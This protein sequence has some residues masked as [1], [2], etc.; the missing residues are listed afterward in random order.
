MSEQEQPD[1]LQQQQQ[2]VDRKGK[3]RAIIH[4]PS[5]RTPLLGGTSQI[6]W[7]V[8]NDVEDSSRA[9]RTL[10]SRLATVFLASLSICTVVF[11]AIA[12]LAWSYAAKAADLTPEDLIN[13]DLVFDGPQKVDLHNVTKDGGIWVTV[14]GRMGV[15]VGDAMGINSDPDDGLLQR[16][17]KKIGRQG[18]RTLHTVSVNLS[19]VTV[20][21]EF[22]PFTTLATLDILPLDLPLTVD[23]PEDDSW[24][25][26]VSLPVLLYPTTN[27][28]LIT[29][30]LRDAWDRGYFAVRADVDNVLVRGGHLDRPSWRTKFHGRLS[31]IRTSLRMKVPSIP[32]LPRPGSNAPF[33]DPSQLITLKSFSIKSSATHL[34]IAAEATTLNPAPQSFQFT[35]PS[36][37]F[38]V[39]MIDEDASLV[40]VASV[41]AEPFTLTHPNITLHVNGSVLPIRPSTFSTL[42]A[43]LMRYLSGLPNRI[44][45]ASSLFP[46]LSIAT[47]FPGPNPRPDVL[48]NVTLRDMKLKTKANGHFLASGTVFARIVLPRGMNIGLNVSRVLPDVLI[49]DGE[50]DRNGDPTSPDPLPDPLPERAFGRIRPE[51]WLIAHSVPDDSSDEGEGSAY[52]V[53]AKVKDV[54]LEVLPGRQKE[55][56]NFVSKVI[57]TSDGAVAGLQ[58]TAAVTVQVDGLPL[59]RPGAASNHLMLAHLPFQGSVRITKKTLLHQTVHHLQYILDHLAEYFPV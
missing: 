50:V 5:E 10:R 42:S 8:V 24:L 2:Q 36:L 43:F 4:E 48:R 21:P 22:D 11:A 39:S 13:N 26:P 40:D 28:S 18:V 20:M 6:P 12:L 14:H 27:S 44:S 15:D 29:K 23:P 1:D 51:D 59:E 45:I 57:F 49:F 31:N 37:P 53:S 34:N 58:G 41:V 54:P 52:T 38:T 16:L 46:T 47:D 19:T 9:R 32:G 30:F 25:T 55:F 7:T 33:P 17:W 35:S 56:S 3:R